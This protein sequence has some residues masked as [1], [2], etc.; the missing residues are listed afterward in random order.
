MR[1]LVDQIEEVLPALPSELPRALDAIRVVGNFAAHPIKSTS[2]SAIV[3]V[4][5]G[6]AEWNLETLEL[7][8]DYYFVRPRVLEEKRAALNKKL[9]DAGKPPLR[10]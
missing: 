4:E 10:G 1:D 5:P 2:T 8:F 3:D 9:A 6:E 7:L